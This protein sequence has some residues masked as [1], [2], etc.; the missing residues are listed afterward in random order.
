MY[1]ARQESDWDFESGKL[2]LD[3]SNTVEWHTSDHPGETLVS[4]ADL[5]AWSEG[6]GLL[7]EQE[8]RDLLADAENHLAE[9]SAALE[10]A[11]R[12]RD[13]IYRIFSAVARDKEPEGMDLAYLNKALTE[14]LVRMQVVPTSTGFEWGWAAYEGSFDR[15]L[16]PIVRSA[17]NLLTS[18]ELNRV[19]E[20]ADDRGCGY[21]FLDTSRN[22]NRRWCSMESCGNR[23]KARRHYKR[24]SQKNNT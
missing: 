20:C 4:Y 3:F 10:K 17:A 16:W 12:L 22:H 19:G 13:A 11:I 18:E 24:L 15:M 2:P 14:V 23:A 1:E 5:V 6:A 21:L 9:A 7:T 8:V